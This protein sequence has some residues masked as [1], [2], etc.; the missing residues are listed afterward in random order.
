MNLSAFFL[1]WS[2]V[3]LVPIPP[4]KSHFRFVPRLVTF[5]LGLLLFMIFAAALTPLS[6][7]VYWLVYIRLFLALLEYAF[8]LGRKREVEEKEEKFQYGRLG[9]RP[10]LGISTRVRPKVVAVLFI[11]F[12]F[13]VLV[14]V[15]LRRFSV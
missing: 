10:K 1:I 8:Q 9:S 6:L 12:L 13:S 2:A 14:G 11:V 15:V 5:L 4:T 7:F 3:F